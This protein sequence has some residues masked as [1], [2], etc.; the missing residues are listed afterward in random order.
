MRKSRI[1][2]FR[3]AVRRYGEGIGMFPV[4]HPLATVRTLVRKDPG[5]TTLASARLHT[6]LSSANNLAC[7]VT[8]PV[9]ATAMDRVGPNND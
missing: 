8:A 6:V 5:D 3:T 4:W 7:F 9:G 1:A 2:Q